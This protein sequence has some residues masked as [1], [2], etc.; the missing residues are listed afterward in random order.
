MAEIVGLAAG[1]LS[2]SFQVYGGISSYVN[3]VRGRKEDLIVVLT[4]VEDLRR[5]LE[6]IHNTVP[7][8]EARNVAAHAAVKAALIL[9]EAEM[10][11]LKNLHDQ[12]VS[13]PVQANGLKALL[14]NRKKS[15]TFPFHQPNIS[16]LQQ[17]LQSANLTLQTAINTVQICVMSSINTTVS[18]LAADSVISNGIVSRMK[19]ALDS[20]SG[21]VSCVRQDLIN[22]IPQ[23]DKALRDLN[24]SLA[25]SV[26]VIRDDAARILYN[27]D[28]LGAGLAMIEG[29]SHA[30]LSKASANEDNL[31]AVAQ[32]MQQLQNMLVMKDSDLGILRQSAVNTFTG[33]GLQGDGWR[34]VPR[35]MELTDRVLRLCSHIDVREHAVDVSE[36]TIID[37]LAAIIHEVLNQAQDRESRRDMR[38]LYGLLTSS[39]N[40]SINQEVMG[41][42]KPVG[43]VMNFALR[44]QKYLLGNNTLTVTTKR[45]GDGTFVSIPRF[46]VNRVLPRGSPVFL[47]IQS[48][49]LEELR[50]LLHSG[51]ASLRDHDEDGNSL[52]ALAVIGWRPDICRFLLQHGANVEIYRYEQQWENHPTERLPLMHISWG[53]TYCDTFIASHWALNTECYKL[54]LDA[55]ADPNDETTHSPSPFFQSPVDGQECVSALMQLM[56]DRGNYFVNPST[57]TEQDMTP[58]LYMCDEFGHNNCQAD[59]KTFIVTASLLLSR[60]ATISETDADKRTCLHLCLESI[61]CLWKYQGQQEALIFLIKRGADVLAKDR[62]GVTVSHSAVWNVSTDYYAWREPIG[63]YTCDLWDFALSACGYD[64]AAVRGNRPFG[65]RYTEH[66]TKQHF[67]AL[68]RGQE[69]LCPYPQELEVQQTDAQGEK[70]EIHCQKWDWERIRK[71]ELD[72]VQTEDP[73]KPANPNIDLRHCDASNAQFRDKPLNDD[74]IMTASTTSDTELLTEH[75]GYPPVSL[76]DDIINSVNILAERAL[77][78]V[79]QG[80]LYAPPEKLGFKIPK[81]SDPDAALD[82]AEQAKNEVE[83]GT[84]QLETLLCASIDRNFDKLEIYVLRNI[85]CVKPVD[86]RNWIRLSHYDGLDFSSLSITETSNGEGTST[87][88]TDKPTLGSIGQLRRKLRESMR[89]NALLHAEQEKNARLLADLRALVGT[90]DDKVKDEDTS[91]TEEDRNVGPM[92]FLRNG[93]AQLKDAGADTPLSTTTAFTLSQLQALRALSTS[94]RTMAPHLKPAEDAA[95]SAADSSS[96]SWRRERLEYVEGATRR[97]LENVQGLELG[98]DGEVRDGEWQAE[99]RNLGNGE[100]EGLEKVVSMLGGEAGAQASRDDGEHMDES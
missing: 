32:Q 71:S 4:Q 24:M 39:Q 40:L 52:L 63:S 100:L 97:H 29:T 85:L 80:L 64:M 50:R 96:K 91:T 37:D 21:A 62:F 19:T 68:W 42:S 95:E 15:F 12:L 22:H 8:L 2:L 36:E 65:V 35:N 26:P 70:P 82:P 58:L 77:N 60:G 11:A 83:A 94:L 18:G 25:R 5:C 43:Q 90:R 69:H 46:C 13:S 49:E 99:G 78:S 27:T 75:F 47:A 56:L 79:E 93:V 88:S 66:Y 9:C 3:A 14:K 51:N 72:L 7:G 45:A 67:R 87:T 16:K 81:N 55:G 73:S 53:V 76:L 44:W 59:M 34:Q 54:L 31:R 10:K 86:I 57:R 17:R 33:S 41:Y 28:Q 23:T 30:I 84:H 89:L 92:A 74:A 1:L 48:G 98:K 6:T 61:T 20:S 38:R